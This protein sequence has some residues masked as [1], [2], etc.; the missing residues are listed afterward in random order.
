[1]E[2][3]VYGNTSGLKKADLAL[4][5]GIYDLAV[6]KDMVI[7]LDI[8]SIIAAVSGGSGRE[9][10]VFIDRRGQVVSVGVGDAATVSLQARGKR[11][12][13]YRLAGLRC[14]HTHP[15]DGGNLSAADYAALYDLRLDAMAAL[16]LQEEAIKEAYLACLGHRDGQLTRNYQTF[17]PLSAGQL[18]KFPLAALMSVYWG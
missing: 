13:A 18:I 3:T 14:I 9:L 11:R 1:M 5:R 2:K 6:D 12:G 10:A 15:S 4:L 7:T 8:A 17:G 16:G